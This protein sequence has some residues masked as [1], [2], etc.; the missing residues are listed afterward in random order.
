MNSTEKLDLAL[1][2][3]RAGRLREAE[4]LYRELLS[5]EPNDADAN[6]LLA[7]ILHSTGRLDDAETL[8]RRAIEAV[9]GEASYQLTLADVLRDRG[10]LEAAVVT[11]REAVCLRPDY[12]LAYNNLA[13]VLRSLR[14]PV[15]AED[16]FRAALRC[17]PNLPE[18]LNNFGT[19]LREQGRLG[20]AREALV[21]A[22]ELRPNFAE[23]HNNLGN[24]S[25]D[26]GKPDVAVSSYRQAIL[27]NPRYGPAHFNL[28][29]ALRRMGRTSEA[30]VAYE[31]A[32]QLVPND[33]EALT[34]VGAVCNELGQ[35]DRAV[36]ACRHAVALRP[37]LALAENN[38]ASSLHMRGE[39]EEA[40]PHYRRAVELDPSDGVNASHLAHAMNF[41]PGLSAEEIFAAHLDWGRRHAD[42]LT[43]SSSIDLSFDRTPGRRLR[44]GYVSPFFREHAVSVFVEPILANHDHE[45]FEVICYSDT[46]TPDGATQRFRGYADR[47]VEAAALDN[48]ALAQQIV[49]D[50]V[51]ILVDLSGHLD[52]HRLLAF[53]RRPAP[54]QVTYI[55]YQN[56]TGMQAMDY[57]LTDAYADPP[58]AT[59]ALHTERLVRL[60]RAYFCYLP[61]ASAPALEPPPALKNGHITFGSFN[62][63]AKVTRETLH[64]WIRILAGVP[65]SRLLILMDQSTVTERRMRSALAEQGVAPDRLE[66][67]GR[68]VRFDYLRL[69]Q[70]VDI[71]LDAFPF[72]GHTTTCEAL[73]MG[74]PVVM[75]A[76]TTY[77]TRFGGVA[78]KVLGLDDLI[79]T[80]TEEYIRIAESLAGD[81]DRLQL[82]RS[83]LR[84]RMRVSPLLD[85]SGFTRHLETAY[86][87]MWREW[88]DAH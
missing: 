10:Q 21:R 5:I 55:G 76:G 66:F 57:R 86:Q 44:V 61:H 74:V 50:K 19:L 30:L 25:R 68:C 32:V 29:N 6:Y 49:R 37:D 39:V 51:N 56:T 82:L 15:E 48:E 7:R 24:V 27:L 72:N 79:A 87:Q 43:A 40:L 34:N 11:Y 67:V 45:A 16:A 81:V 62:K 18:A 35:T 70:R 33:A 23:A 88:C 28:G 63:V 58:G 20:E 9:P 60:P 83:T 47:W 64:T 36:E 42:P 26:E 77:V 41:A 73:W 13:N 71:A 59:D 52:G 14:K 69:H 17:Q 1:S 38:L 53:A 84:D 85:F 3:H 8:A 75:L 4:Q 54:V 12:A 22:I 80:S 78:L 65:A 46:R 31:A 2:H